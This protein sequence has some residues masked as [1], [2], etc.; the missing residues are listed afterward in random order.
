M[1][2]AC[3]AVLTILSIL[4]LPSFPAAQNVQ[5]LTQHNDNARTGANLSETQLNVS[6]VSAGDFGFVFSLPVDGAVYAQPL[7]VPAL[8]VHDSVHNVVYIATM[9]N[10]VYAFDADNPSGLLLWQHN[11]GTSVPQNFMPMSEAIAGQTAADRIKTIIHFLLQGCA[12]TTPISNQPYV[13][14]QGGYGVTSTPVIDPTSNT[15]FAVAKTT[16]PKTTDPSGFAYFLHALNLETGVERSGS[17]VLISGQVPGKGVGQKDGVLS[18]DPKM[19]LQRPGL[20]LSNGAVYIAFGAHQDTP[21]YHGWIFAYDVQTL[22]KK[23]AFST[24]PNAEQ[25]GIWQSG[26]GLAADR[27]GNIYYMTGNGS[28]DA[29]HGG[30]DLGDSFVKLDK[31]LNIADWFTPEDFDY[32]DSADGDLGSA[33]PILLPLSSALLGGGKEGVFYLLDP[34]HMGHLEDGSH[35]PLQKFQASQAADNTLAD[36]IEATLLATAAYDLLVGD[37]LAA[38]LLAAAPVVSSTKLC[39]LDSHHIHGSPV[40]WNSPADGPLV[41]V[42]G[43]RDKLKAFRFDPV[44]RRFPSTSPAYMTAAVSPP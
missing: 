30:T 44:T 24:T 16:V 9:H 3:I 43:E 41:Y 37:P 33:G 28:F 26:N 22:H 34:G 13:N 7:Y 25:G 29:D 10:N 21:P 18:F 6:N 42:W 14:I 23:A 38:A 5:V 11:L 36:V 8:T 20:L 17:P 27:S 32:M 35:P 19:H 40:V 12:P 39:G 15:L 4:S 2:R 1:S 31:N